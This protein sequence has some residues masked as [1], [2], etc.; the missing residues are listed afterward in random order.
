[1]FIQIIQGKV[2]DPE[3]L[4]RQ[5]ERWQQ[6][7]KSGATGYLGSTGGIT[8][9]GRSI[10]IVRFDSEDAAQANSE[11]SEQGAWWNETEKAFDGEVTFKNSTKV[12]LLLGGGS[13]D[14]GF[15][16]VMQGRAKDEEQMRSTMNEVEGQ[17]RESRPDVIGILVAWHG[18]NE[19]T[20]AV[21]F[22]S[23]E[24]ARQGEQSTQGDEI[25]QDFA[26][27]MDGELTF[28]D[29]PEPALD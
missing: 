7:L 15:V 1:M 6:E 14:A 28:I 24:A 5:H 27:L 9:D 23:E 13:N 29:L 8:P 10:M 25:D 19:F 12:D 2:K 21:Y 16:Q 4:Q 17:L 26:D 20:Q 18:N 22:T 3:L 11:R